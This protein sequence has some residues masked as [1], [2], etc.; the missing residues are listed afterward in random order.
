MT[1]NDAIAM[2]NWDQ[3]SNDKKSLIE[4][5]RKKERKTML[6]RKLGDLFDG[7]R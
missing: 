5:Q 4:W 1:F 7:G 3:M 2:L 6:T